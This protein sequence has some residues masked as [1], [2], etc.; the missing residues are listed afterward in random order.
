MK[1]ARVL[2]DAILKA[3]PP[4]ELG[5]AIRDRVPFDKLKDESIAAVA[6]TVTAYESGLKALIAELAKEVPEPTGTE[7]EKAAAALPEGPIKPDGVSPPR[8]KR[9]DAVVKNT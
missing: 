8:S 6:V 9:S 7:P 2:Y 3:N 5:L 4:T 1:K